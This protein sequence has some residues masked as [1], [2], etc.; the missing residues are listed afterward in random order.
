MRKPKTIISSSTPAFPWAPMEGYA[1]GTYGHR[2][3]LSAANYRQQSAAANRDFA[4]ITPATTP[5]AGNFVPLT[6]DGFLPFIDTIWRIMGHD[7][8][9]GSAGRLAHGSL[10]RVRAYSSTTWSATA[11]TH[12]FGTASQRDFDAGGLR[13]GQLVANL[14][15]TRQYDIGFA[16]PLSVAVGGEFRNE[17]FQIRPGDLQSFATGPLFRA[18]FATPAA[19]C[20]TQVGV[21][22][23]GTG[24]CSFPGRAAPAGAQGFPGIP[25][26]ARRMKAATVR[27]LCGADTNP[28]EG[29]TTVLAGRYSTL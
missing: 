26:P 19:N 23:A 11:S 13:Y 3:G 25:T 2:D 16:T 14:D 12:R 5:N 9:P 8:H 7:R 24:I 29:F 18:S 22:N 28:F 21:F 4:T 15:F 20:A 17:N 27:C 1:F 6:P 10:R